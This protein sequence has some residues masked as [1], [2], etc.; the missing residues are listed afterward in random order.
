MQIFYELVRKRKKFYL[1]LLNIT[2]AFLIQAQ[3]S[4][5]YQGVIF[6]SAST[7]DYTPFWMVSNTYGVTPLRANNVYAREAI[8]WNHSF[9]KNWKFSLGLD[10]IEA[11]RH[12]SSLYIQQLY[13][14]LS[15]Q[16]LFLTVG[17]KEK[18]NSMLDKIL[19]SGDFNY[20]TNARPLPEIK[21]SI[22]HFVGIPYTQ[23][24]VS[25]RGDFA[26]GKSTD[27]A[28]ILR[29]KGP[30]EEYNTDLLWHHKSAFL[31][32]QDPQR[33]IP[34]SLMLGLDHAV[35]YGG[36]VTLQGIGKLP[37]SLSDF[38][39]ICLVEGGG[40]DAPEGDQINI[41]GN[42]QGT[43]NFK[44]GYHTRI[45]DIYAYK[46]HYADDASGLEGANWR[47]GIW[48][49]ESSFHH[50]SYLKKIVLEFINTTDQSGPMHFLSYGDWNI[51]ARGG[52]N[53]DYYNHDYY[54][55]GWSYF[56]RSLGSPLISSP[57]YNRD[58]TLYFKNNRF[59]AIHLGL[60]G[61]I[62]PALEYRILSTGSRNWG[63]MSY[64]FRKRMDNFSFLSEF[65]YQPSRW[66]G[67]KIGLQVAFDQGTLYGNNCGISL[68][69]S[70]K[71]VWS[72]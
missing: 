60:N 41:L 28:Y 1:F 21:I 6:G 26:V 19:S 2:I 50:F 24:I 67:W 34:F 44:L 23:G 10:I 33:K 70:K 30:G 49:I 38:F 15:F 62:L 18:Y 7:G 22:P 55:S 27:N 36:W 31:L 64:P 43:Y 14:E 20:S 58:G 59:K 47:D 8:S 68:S 57:E 16:H 4:L 46:Q 9:N 40:D 53:D 39:R 48:G 45:F 3:D 42:H 29:T 61:N 54:I 32:F 5:F 11:A 13:G 56:G 69:L 51:K 72:F 35:Q 66:K 65:H 52:G 17:Q 71:G 12:S 63:R 25:F 37:Q